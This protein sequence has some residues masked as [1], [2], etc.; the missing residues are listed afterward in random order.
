MSDSKTAAKA[1]QRPGY[2]TIADLVVT[3]ASPAMNVWPEIEREIR[4]RLSAAMRTH[5]PITVEIKINRVK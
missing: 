3:I 5:D 2:D 4:A 1:V